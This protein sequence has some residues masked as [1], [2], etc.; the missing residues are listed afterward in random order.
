[1]G[2]K[3]LRT[4]AYS[5][6]IEEVTRALAEGADVKSADIF[7][8]TALHFAVRK[9]HD[10]VVAFLL[11]SGAN[12][13]AADQNGVTALHM[14]S[15]RQNEEIVKSLLAKE[16]NINAQNASYQTPLMYAAKMSIMKNVEILLKA[17]ADAKL[18]DEDGKTAGYLYA[19]NDKCKIQLLAGKK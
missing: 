4:S 1:M 12:V 14:A 18:R 16:P 13:N 6:E 15:S 17:G 2:N 9:Q 5:G 11:D 8:N 7:G 3:L 10:S 19:K